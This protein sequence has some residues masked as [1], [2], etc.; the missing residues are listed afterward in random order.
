MQTKHGYHLATYLVRFSLP[1]AVAAGLGGT[2]HGQ[3]DAPTAPAPSSSAPY[4][5]P[6]TVMSE[7]TVSDV[8]TS[9]Q[10]LPTVRP[11]GDV[12]GDDANIIDIPRSVSSV[13]EAWMQ[14]RMVK[15][16]MD[17]GQFSPGVYS[18]AQ[19]G[20]PAVPFIRGDLGQ[21]YVD[22]QIIPFTRNSAPPSFNGVE[23]LDI[24]KGPGSAVYG[25]QGEGAGGYVDFVMKEP[26]FDSFHGDIT[27]TY[28]DWTSGH[29][30]S[31]P[32]ATIDLGGPITSK[33][34][35]RV[36]YL[37]RYGDGYYINDHDQ[38]QDLYAALTYLPNPNVKI[39]GW[40]QIFSDR[41]NEITGANR[42]TQQ[43]IWNGD[44]IAGPASPVT[45]GPNA[46]FGYDIATPGTP[47][48]P[49]NFGTYPDG[50]YQTVTASTAHVVKL[51]DYDALI[52]PSDTARSKLFQSQV[53]ATLDVGPDAK[54]VNR[55]YF[56]LG[57]SE[58]YETYGY[59]E[60]VPR[61]ESIQDRLEFH[62]DFNLG[63]FANQLITGGD[64]RYQELIS[65][66]DFTSEPFSN[67]DLSAPLSKIFYPGY[68]NEGMTWGGGVQVPGAPGYS[69]NAESPDTGGSAGS[70]WSYIYDSA[71]FAQDEVK[72]SPKM[73]L[74][75]GYRLDHIYAD[76]A[77]P[78]VVEVGYEA[79]FTYYP[80]TTPIYIPRGHSSPLIVNETA[81]GEGI[82]STYEGYNVNDAVNDQ[83]YF[84]SWV[85]KL[86]DASS[87]YATYDRVDAILGSANFGGVD[88]NGTQA[89]THTSLANSLTTTSTV[90][91]IGYK[92]SFLQNKLYFSA[93]LFQQL[94]YGAELTG[95]TFPI[96]D[97]GLELEAVYQPSKQW[98]LNANCAYQDA[99]AFGNSF[100]QQT[101]NYL[102]NFATTTPVDG[103]TGTGL[104]GPN[105]TSYDPPSGRMRAPGIP[106]VQ[107]NAF[108]E[109]KDPTG[110]GIGAGPQ[111]IGRQ[112]ANDQDTLHI[113]GEYEMDGYVFYGQ[114]RWDVRV[115]VKN[116]FNHRLLDPIDVTFAGNDT[117]FVRP[118]ISASITFR[119]HF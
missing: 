95:Q 113:P 31:N 19:Y 56:A 68:Y 4:T 45:S 99:T 40:A 53:K 100:Y 66:Q 37:S 102:D 111:F 106:Q 63:S 43:F 96:K 55:A 65:Y 91:E 48:G 98:T 3:S 82:H 70:Q 8:P 64:F 76:T 23:S 59:D 44:Y 78:P 46:Y 112:Y 67:Y 81:F 51:P 83:S 6:T 9:E 50:T 5:G 117:I 14:D 84:L 92:E 86:N 79:F 16:A 17:F 85:Y 35:Y 7:M 34:A 10:V 28:G 21:M 54:L 75:P 52:G 29:S 15:N 88:V 47:P 94:K 13:N 109:Y 36:S 12:M 58:K 110:W 61:Q 27:A 77:N 20:I 62:D 89:N 49:D 1:L 39:E 22:G 41:T 90:Y 30:Y 108:A 42:V 73:S 74:I 33:L 107:A 32:E 87:F 11:V 38:T 119:Y 60:Y 57:D 26:Y 72:V 2:L 104:G 80:L 69:S 71:V 115:N 18:A 97:N 25:P 24:V 93:A 101:G 118:P 103:T 116:M 105:F 114:K